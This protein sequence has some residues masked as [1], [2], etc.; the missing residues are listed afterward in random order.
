MILLG[1]ALHQLKNLTE[2]VEDS[3]KSIDITTKESV[4]LEGLSNDLKRVYEKEMEKLMQV[5]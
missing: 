2:W 3:S 5:I 1:E 4:A